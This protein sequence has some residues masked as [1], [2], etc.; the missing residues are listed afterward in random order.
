M[1]IHSAKTNLTQWGK[2]RLLLAIAVILLTPSLSLTAQ[3]LQTTAREI[4]FPVSIQWQRQNGVNRY[5]LQIAADERF[6]NVFLDRRVIGDRY[7]VNEL[8]PGYYYWR[9]APAD[10]SQLGEF[11]KPIRFFISGGTVTTVN[12]PYHAGRATRS[13]STPAN[14]SRKVQTRSSSER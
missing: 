3:A 10:Y 5:R 2:L 12:L 13:H 1:S 8:S 4:A 9:V 11:S 6:Q 7:L 14:T